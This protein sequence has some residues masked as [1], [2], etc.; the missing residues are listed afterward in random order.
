[1]QSVFETHATFAAIHDQMGDPAV[2]HG[3]L[4]VKVRALRAVKRAEKKAPQSCVP[5]IAGLRVAAF[6][7]R[8]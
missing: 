7:A 6:T 5:R 4:D 2:A 1:V 8:G 3:A